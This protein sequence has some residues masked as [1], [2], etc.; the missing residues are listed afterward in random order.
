MNNTELINAVVDIPDN[1]A[2]S[3][4]F[5]ISVNAETD[6]GN[7]WADSVCFRGSANDMLK[8]C[9]D[10]SRLG[11]EPAWGLPTFRTGRVY[12]VSVCIWDAFYLDDEEH[13]EEDAY[14]TVSRLTPLPYTLTPSVPASESVEEEE[15]ECPEA[16]CIDDEPIII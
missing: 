3:R 11:V 7:D 14:Y 15:Y 16:F 5:S 4:R 8:V 2:F 6:K 1:H 9:K 12:E 10:L 13:A